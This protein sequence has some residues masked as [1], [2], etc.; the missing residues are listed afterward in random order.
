[1]NNKDIYQSEDTRCCETNNTAA[2]KIG[3][4]I[5]VALGVTVSGCTMALLVALTV[6][7]ICRLF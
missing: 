6:K 7:L 4:A 3:N 2:K 5:G 1:M